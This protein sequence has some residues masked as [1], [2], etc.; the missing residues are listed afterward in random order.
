[1]NTAPTRPTSAFA[2]AFKISGLGTRAT[3]D[4]MAHTSA[5]GL[6]VLPR[7]QVPIAI[8][9]YC[10]DRRAAGACG[11]AALILQTRRG[12]TNTIMGSAAFRGIEVVVEA[13]T[14]AGPT[15][16]ARVCAIELP[17]Q[18]GRPPAKAIAP[19]GLPAA[20]GRFAPWEDPRESVYRQSGLEMM[21]H[22]RSSAFGILRA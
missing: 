22:R 12:A 2:I 11:F 14:G 9:C 20:T 21:C 5:K 8:D 3:H 6:S 17:R 18:A 16:H 1:M 4:M 13:G 10:G 7:D 19:F 15:R